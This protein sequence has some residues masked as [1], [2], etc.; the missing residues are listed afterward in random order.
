MRNPDALTLMPY[1]PANPI[2]LERLHSMCFTPRSL[3]WGGGLLLLI[4]GLVSC[5][6]TARNQ[7]VAA[8]PKPAD[9]SYDW[10]IPNESW[11]TPFKDEQPIL[12]LA[13]TQNPAEWDKLPA[14]WNESTEKT[15][16]PK[17]GVPVERNVVRIKVPLGLT[18]VPVSPVENPITVGK[19]N[20]GKK[21]YFDTI[22]SS[23]STVA[24]A[25]CHD[26][27]KGYTDQ[28]PVSTGINGKKGG[29]S[30]PTVLNSAFNR[31][32]FWDGRAATLEDQS[33][34]PP[35]N[36]VEMFDGA[37]H[38]WHKVIER[39]RKKPEYVKMFREVFGTEPTRDGTAKAIAAYER[40]VF[41]GNS[42]YDRADLA[43]RARV[44]EEGTGKYDFKPVDFETA[45]KGAFKNKDENAL[46]SLNLDPTRDATRIAET[47]AALERGRAL[48][49]GKARCNSC[50]VGDNF[51]D[52]DFHNL[53]VGVKEGILP[54]ESFGRHSAQPLGHKNPDYIGAFKTPTL[55]G[56][57]NTAP[58][59]HDGSEATLEKVVDFYDRGGNANEFLDTKM[60]DYEAEKAYLLAQQGGAPY[61]GPEVKL[62]GKDRKPIVPLH[63][64]LTE[65]E[66]KDL[67]LFLRSLQGD[68]VDPK[69]AAE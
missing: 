11:K 4:L 39:L 58:Y 65:A 9:A 54:P 5:T 68:P 38:A 1:L 23:D 46:K 47:A 25:S 29:V 18:Q 2:P 10:Q 21:L 7:V 66:K 53:G 43:M 61:K 26:P 31:L 14:F 44:E 60:R 37:G 16:D 57:L 49:F 52:N 50:H 12:F 59:L 36:P 24:C 6:I 33:Q 35:Q 40:T 48:F 22:L 28:S 56:L 20:L 41:S 63:L 34:G 19:W 42:I 62:F 3:F 30:A 13:R 27:R 55:R 45:L 64:K 15:L 17:T 67:V 32:Q 69:V 8:D 51:T